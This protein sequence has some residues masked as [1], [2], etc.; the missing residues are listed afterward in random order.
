MTAL[1]PAAAWPLSSAWLRSAPR[2][3]PH[4]SNPRGSGTS[5]GGPEGR[6]S[7]AAGLVLR[8]HPRLPG[9]D[10]QPE[11]TCWLGAGE[12][13]GLPRALRPAACPAA[14]AGGD[15]LATQSL[16]VVQRLQTPLRGA[17]RL[18]KKAC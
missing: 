18:P 10:L 7:E 1:P 8:T 11:L 16:P 15:A 13:I 4:C 17:A 6:R 3:A 9:S 12:L 5:A 14:S 2:C